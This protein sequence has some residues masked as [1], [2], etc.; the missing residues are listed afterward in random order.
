MDDLVENVLRSV[1]EKEAK[2]KTTNVE[3]AIDLDIDEGNLLTCDAN[4]LDVTVFRYIFY[5]MFWSSS[6]VRGE[7]SIRTPPI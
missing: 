6:Q 7:I 5:I 1:A 3:K 2:Y 4:P